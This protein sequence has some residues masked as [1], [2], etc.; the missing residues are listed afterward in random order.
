MFDAAGE[1]RIEL[2]RV[3][4]C[5]DQ[6]SSRIHAAGERRR[7]RK[8]GTQPRTGNR[9]RSRPAQ[10]YPLLPVVALSQGC[11]QMVTFKRH[12]TASGTFPPGCR[13]CRSIHNQIKNITVVQTTQDQPKSRYYDE[14]VTYVAEITLVVARWHFSKFPT[15]NG[16]HFEAH[17]GRRVAYHLTMPSS[18][19]DL[20][21]IFST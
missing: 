9:M 17:F 5:R 7:V 19:R 15:P 16:L 20:D 13:I 21:P 11:R 10:I 14:K 12:I 2:T 4:S 18:K 3:E 6:S 8:D 1:P